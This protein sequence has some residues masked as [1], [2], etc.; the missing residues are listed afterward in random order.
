VVTSIIFALP[1]LG[2]LIVIGIRR[3]VFKP[4]DV[5]RNIG[6]GRYDGL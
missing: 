5:Q 1:V 6:K 4:R 3:G 2:I